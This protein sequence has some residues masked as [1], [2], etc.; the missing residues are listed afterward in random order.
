MRTK[1]R[2]QL[3][4]GD[5]HKKHKKHEGNASIAKWKKREDIEFDEED[6]CAFEISMV[7]LF[8]LTIP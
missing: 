8:I 3:K 7:I 1:R 5:N 4:K 6:A 2:N